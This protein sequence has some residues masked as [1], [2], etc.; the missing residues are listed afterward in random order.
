MIKSMIKIIML[1]SSIALCFLPTL[2]NA[3]TTSQLQPLDSFSSAHKNL[4]RRG[5]SYYYYDY[6]GYYNYE[7]YYGNNPYYYYYTPGLQYYYGGRFNHGY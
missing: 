3:S 5:V 1:A 4:A 6:P 2:S 7:S